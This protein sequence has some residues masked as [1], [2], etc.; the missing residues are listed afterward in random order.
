MKIRRYTEADDP[1][2]MQLERLC[3]RGAPEPFV[4]YRRRFVDRAVLFR[5]HFLVLI[6]AEGEI[7][8]VVA[9]AV[10]DTNVRG[11]RLRLGYIFDVRVHPKMRRQGIAAT[12]L[13]N[14]DEE[15]QSMGCDGSY[16]HIVATNVASLRLFAGRGYERRRQLR[17]LTYQPIPLF[18]Y[19]PLDVVRQVNPHAAPVEEYF[20]NYDMFVDDVAPSLVPYQFECWQSEQGSTIS[21]Y[22]QSKL[23][24]Q[25]PAD[26]PW[27][28][29]EEVA[30]RGRHWR[31]FHPYGKADDLEMLFA[32]IRDQ[33]VG[34]NINKLTMVIDAEDPIPSFFYAETT[35]QREYVVVTRPYNS[36]WDGLLGARFY[37]DTREL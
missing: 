30:R 14:L 26:A 16:A 25:V 18:L 37:C 1:A 17:Y 21:L 23:F 32:T 2:L 3:P 36:S 24:Q 22:D 29:P 8:A 11:Q 9:T 12:L 7:V 20:G 19:D 4:H 28:S 33:A 35:S 27:P 13:E 10:K 5:E 6:E 15:L 34:E 31:I